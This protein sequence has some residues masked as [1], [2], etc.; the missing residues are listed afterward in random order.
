MVEIF[1]Y[2]NSIALRDSAYSL[3][4]CEAEIQPLSWH[5]G[6]VRQV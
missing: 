5:Y 4:C 2:E 1:A 6:G 3:L